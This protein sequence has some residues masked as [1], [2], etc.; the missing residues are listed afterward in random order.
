MIGMVPDESETCCCLCWTERGVRT[1]PIKGW[2]GFPLCREH[3]AQSIARTSGEP[4]LDIAPNAP[5][6]VALQ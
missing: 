6:P 2:P 4:K 1:K 3:L 5:A